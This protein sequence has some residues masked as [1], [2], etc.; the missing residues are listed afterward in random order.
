M[1]KTIIFIVSFLF[2]SNLFAQ[3]KP[4]KTVL[5]KSNWEVWQDKIPVS[6][7]VRVGLMF[8]DKVGNFNSS[9]FFVM[10]P[11]TEIKNLCIELSSKD[12]RYSAKLNYNL[13]DV[14]EGLQQFYLPTKYKNELSRYRSD[15]VVILASLNMICKQK[16]DSYLISGWNYPKKATSA[17]VYINSQ[18]PTT[19]VVNTKRKEDNELQCTELE[20]PT[21]AFNKKCVIPLSILNFDSLLFI[22][23]RIRRMGRVKFNSYQIPLKYLKLE[24][25]KTK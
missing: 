18:I 2:C 7:G 6:G 3:I 8:E 19:L 4:N 14:E 17:I 15:E 23:Q 16:P 1:I 24:N 13:K 21:I 22:K 20:S 11:K 10:V 9:Q 25:K 5:E 12:G